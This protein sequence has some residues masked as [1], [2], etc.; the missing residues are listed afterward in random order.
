MRKFIFSL[1][2]GITCGLS[3]QEHFLCHT[4]ELQNQW[5]AKHPE[6]KARF[7]QL[8]QEAANTD[9]EMAKT[10][11]KQ[12]GNAQQRTAAAT[13]VSN[14][15]VPIVFHILHTG[16][17]ENISDAQVMDAVSILTRD[18]NKRN[19]DTTD[20]V[21]QFQNIIGN[22]KFEFQLA[23]KDPN[24]NCTN[25]IIRHWDTNTDWTE[26]FND[27]VYTWP[28]TKYLNVYVVKTMMSGFAG[29]TYNPGAG[30]PTNADAVVI[31]SSYVGS[32]GSGS[33]LTSRALTH[34]V[35]HWFNLSHTW[36]GTNQPG[37]AC[38]DDGVSDTPIT[39]GYTACNLNNASICNPNIVENM[40]NYMD[41]AY[42]QR[43]YTLGQTTRMINSINSSINGRNNLSTTAN[44]A[45]TGVTSPGT[46][47]IPGLQIASL[48]T[49]TMCAGKS[50]NLVTYTFNAIPASY[51]WTSTGT[52]AIFASPA[53][54]VTAV[55]YTSPG[56]KTITCV[57][58]NANGSVSQSLVVLVKDATPQLTGNNAESFENGIIPAN[59]QQVDPTSPTEQG[60]IS[61]DGASQGAYSAYIAGESFN[62]NAIAILESPSYDFK[63]NPG[64]VF[65]FNY[66]YAKQSTTNKDVFKVQ[67]SKDCE[68][69][70]T[71]IYAPSNTNLCQNS[72]SVT[73]TLFYPTADQ[74]K[75]YD[76]TT[77]S[78]FAAF[79]SEP[80]VIIRFF[81]EEDVAGTGSGNRFYLDEINFTAPVGINE[82]TKQL[83]FNV[84]PNPT[85]AAFNL[86]FTLSD[87]AKIKYEVVS[88]TGSVL[89]SEPEKV[90]T[91]GVHEFKVNENGKLRAG[92]YFINLE[93]NGVKMSK[94][95]IV[96]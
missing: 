8:Q 31:L 83:D 76:I 22:P 84:Y 12:G 6:Y 89:I 49:L 4:T 50:L 17:G 60:E 21:S 28:P 41:Y 51:A 73:S 36:G 53:G 46:G 74:W 40:Q 80:N 38:G 25:G 66:A 24:G 52:D 34:E 77:L 81:F 48:P 85:S 32:I 39:K 55:T 78:S 35:G 45:I 56:T 79:K 65:T 87:A 5:F 43:M 33:N 90:I 86:S 91:Q 27:Y 44:L 63:H 93:F 59:W 54:S 20:V 16:G 67:A 71:D 23:T 82:L 95:I 10:G 57:A 96:E 3:A 18:Y 92:I 29:Y 11:Y 1:A 47:C 58:A 30:V 7:D 88:V 61:T 69:T 2:M 13:S 42:C 37:V 26:N 70:W 15:T 64:A 72:G 19:A 75:T 9:A 14:Y 62:A 94:K 68:G